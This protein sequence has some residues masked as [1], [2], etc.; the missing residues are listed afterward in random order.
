MLFTW[1]KWDMFVRRASWFSPRYYFYILDKFIN[2][3][4]FFNLQ[5]ETL[6]AKG[7]LTDLYKIQMPRIHSQEFI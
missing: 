7:L 5:L 1:F 6:S 4:H 2:F 3:N